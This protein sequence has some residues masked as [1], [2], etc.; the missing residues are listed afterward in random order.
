MLPLRRSFGSEDTFIDDMIAE[1]KTTAG[2]WSLASHNRLT[3]FLAK[4]T[5][6]EADFFGYQIVHNLTT[7]ETGSLQRFK[8][9]QLCTTLR[10]SCP[11]MNAIFHEFQTD[12][13]SVAARTEDPLD[14]AI[15]KLLNSLFEPLGRPRVIPCPTV[16]PTCR[17]TIIG[18]RR[19]AVSRTPQPA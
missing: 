4:A 13:L 9:A 6:E 17:A 1:S 18:P 16:V 8:L 10:R 11:R 12:I 3:A 5:P 7:P 2:T 19:P 14:P 15:S